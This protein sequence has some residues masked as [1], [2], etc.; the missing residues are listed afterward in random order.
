MEGRF[1]AAA[2]EQRAG[3]T[4]GNRLYKTVENTIMVTELER[5]VK[6]QR[7]DLDLVRRCR[8]KKEGILPDKHLGVMRLEKNPAKTKPRVQEFQAGTVP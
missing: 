4:P 7:V 2:Y 5:G 3:Q 6:A 1:T 8:N